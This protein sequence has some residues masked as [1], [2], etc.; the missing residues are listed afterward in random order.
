[1]EVNLKMSR[2]TDSLSLMEESITIFD[3]LSLIICSYNTPEI[4][5][6]CLKSFVFHH[7]NGP[8]K[9]IIIEN[10]TNDKTQQFLDFNNI[11]YVKNPKGTHSPSV[12][13]GLSLAK[14]K[15]CL[16]ID[17][18]IIFKR[19]V[20]EVFTIFKEQHL[21]LLG[22]IQGDR[23]GFLLYP[24]VAP[25]FCFINIDNIR[26]KKINF[27]NEERVNN[28]NSMG[29][30]K[31][32]PINNGHRNQKYYDVGSVFFEDVQ[33]NNLGISNLANIDS[34]ILH[35]ESLSWAVQ[36]NIDQY[37]K[38]GRSRCDSFY[39]AAIEYKDVDV[40]NCFQGYY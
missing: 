25:Y 38:M 16:L 17:T 36:T 14:T 4:L 15:Y 6:L 40:K 10:S 11:T 31:N 28:T 20:G 9:I 29:F 19:N 21:T 23:G 34:Y 27:H 5:E 30:F 39:E 1:V 32:I 2:Q 37:I 35:A 13:I 24:R 26:N 18:D 12:D 33:K 8:H 3:D 22:E 7:G